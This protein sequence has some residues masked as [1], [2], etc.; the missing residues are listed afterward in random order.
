MDRCTV[1]A[2]TDSARRTTVLPIPTVSP[3]PGASLVQLYTSFAYE[4]PAL[5]PR[6][7]RE[8]AECLARDGFRSV[9]EA[10]GADHP[11]V[12]AKARA[13]AAGRGRGRAAGAG[14][15]EAAAGAE[16]K[17]WFGWW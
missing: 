9:E 10:V 15:G 17:S 2:P 14:A 3:P 11:D 4:G 6:L 8:L 5:L 1:A 16:R 7:K 12:R 13:G